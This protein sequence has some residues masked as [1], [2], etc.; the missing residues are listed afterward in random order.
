MRDRLHEFTPDT[1]VVLVTFT[2][3]DRLEAYLRR[4]PLP[5][6]VLIDADRSTYRAYGLGRTSIARAWGIRPALAYVRLLL[7]GRW[8]DLRRPVEDTLQLGGDFVI[9][10]GGALAWGFWGEGPDDRPEVATL[11]AEVSRARR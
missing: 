4:N 6:P 8:R 7:R 9:A 10:P 5:F 1:A 11:A 3:P 2:E